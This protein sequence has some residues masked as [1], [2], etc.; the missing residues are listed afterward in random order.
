MGSAL[1]V[2]QAGWCC[3]Q[4]SQ[5]LEE[6]LLVAFGILSMFFEHGSQGG[7]LMRFQWP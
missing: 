2:D 6:D 7:N 3:R 4:A 5:A 1:T